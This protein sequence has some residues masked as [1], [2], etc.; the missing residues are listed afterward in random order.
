VIVC[1]TAF[2]KAH[3]PV[4]Y[5]TAL[6][7]VERD[8]TDKIGQVTADCHRM[9][10][11]LLRPSVSRSG[12]NFRIEPLEERHFRPGITRKRGIRFGLSAVKNVGEGAVEAILAGRSDEPF[13]DLEDF[14]HRVDLRLVGKRALESLIRVGALEDFGSRAGLLT[15]LDS[16]VASSARH[17]E[18]IESGQMSFFGAGESAGDLLGPIPTPV[19]DRATEL[20][21]EKELIGLYL[22]EH[23]LHSLAEAISDQVTVLI[24]DLDES[25]LGQSVTIAGM[26]EDVRRITTKKGAAMVFAR[27]VDLQGAVDLTVFP[28]TLEATRDLWH[29]DRVLVV[30]GR[31][32]QR[33]DRIQVVVD[34]T[35]PF[36]TESGAGGSLHTR[37]A[38]AA[39]DLERAEEAPPLRSIEVQTDPNYQLTVTLPRAAS[40][41]DDIALLKRVYDT[42]MEYQGDDRFALRVE[43]GNGMVELDFPNSSTRYCVSLTQRLEELVGVGGLRAESR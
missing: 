36:E 39:G 22:S 34:D 40:M 2:L 1:Q 33:D 37:R 14:C 17:H 41:E 25:Y 29:D 32:E 20:A 7:A 13:R 26:T 28:R 19:T 10:I 16:V 35:W 12:P 31:V 9:G 15:M 27:L 30:R 4:E 5:M 18:A 23:P 24:G 3:Y 6:L 21:W 43:N 11:R 42:L 38:P 8:N